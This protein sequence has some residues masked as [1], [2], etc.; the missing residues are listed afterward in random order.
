MRATFLFKERQLFTNC[1]FWFSTEPTIGPL[2]NITNR[3]ISNQHLQSLI[4]QLR[5]NR[6]SIENSHLQITKT[7]S[8]QSNEMLWY[9]LS[10]YLKGIPNFNLPFHHEVAFWSSG[11]RKNRL[12]ARLMTASYIFFL[13]VLRM[14]QIRLRW[15]ALM[16]VFCDMLSS[17]LGVCFQPLKDCFQTLILS[18]LQHKKMLSRSQLLQQPV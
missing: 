3:I 5:L 16:F 9:V 13:L 7:A 18:K 6:L 15:K 11:S 2:K 14:L 10:A 4:V 12:P 1:K 17:C 8:Q